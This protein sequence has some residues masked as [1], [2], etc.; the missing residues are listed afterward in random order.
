MTSVRDIYSFIDSFA[1]FAS[2]MD[3]DNS[4]LQTGD[5]AMP[6]ERA[7]VCLDATP[8]VIE[9][10]ARAKCGLLITHHPV[11]FHARRQLLSDDPAWL[12]ARRGM[13]C[14][15]SHT[16]LDIWSVNDL[17]AQRLF[18]G[19]VTRLNELIR[20]CTLSQPMDAATL[21][22]HAARRL[23]A[24]VRYCDAGRPIAAVAVCGGLGCKLIGEV[25]GRAG[26]EGVPDAFLTGDAG[27]HDFLD[28]ARHGLTLLAAGH[29]ET[30]IHIVPALAEKLRAAFPAV[31]WLIPN[32]YGVINYA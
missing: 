14:I 25:I 30:E 19:R 29:F 18:P 28:A 4:G 27:H 20:V 2:Q 31:E 13:A 6:V 32:E 3:F 5:F 26:E 11:L 21:A 12:L 7:M 17:L 24:Q 16:P 15:A 22:A 9:Q 10:A 1:P 8:A 23:N